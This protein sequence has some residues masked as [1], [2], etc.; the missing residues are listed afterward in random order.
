MTHHNT[1]VK[2]RNALVRYFRLRE[3]SMYQQQQLQL[4][5]LI[6]QKMEIHTEDFA[7]YSEWDWDRE[8]ETDCTPATPVSPP[9]GCR[10]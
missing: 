9:A 7:E 3:M 8:A 10:S 6:V 4:V 2:L 5:R 1:V